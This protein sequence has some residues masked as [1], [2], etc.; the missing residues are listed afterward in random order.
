MRSV[1]GTTTG[2]RRRRAKLPKSPLAVL[3]YDPDRQAYVEDDGPAP[4]TAARMLDAIHRDDKHRAMYEEEIGFAVDPTDVIAIRYVSSVPDHVERVEVLPGLWGNP[5]G[6]AN[7][8]ANDLGDGEPFWVWDVA[9]SIAEARPALEERRSSTASTT[10]SDD[11]ESAAADTLVGPAGA[12]QPSAQ[13]D[14]TTEPTAVRE[15]E[16]RGSYDAQPDGPPNTS[17]PTEDQ[18]QRFQFLH[19]Y[20][21]ERLELGVGPAML[22]FSRKSKTFGYFAPE[23][24]RRG[25]KEGPALSEISLN[26]DGLDRDPRDSAATI[27]HELVHQWHHE[28]GKPG[29]RGYHNKEWAAKME[30]IGLMP[31]ST[32]APG[33]DKTG[34]RVSHYI[35]EG[36]PFA[37]AFA[38]LPPGAL[39]PFVSG[40]PV[41]EPLP[42]TTPKPKDPSKTPFVCAAG[43]GRKWW[44]KAS[45]R[46]SVACKQ[47]GADF[48]CE[49]ATGTDTGTPDTKGCEAGN[50]R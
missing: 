37:V 3:A 11:G 25:E 40:A 34:Q 24:W 39:L 44:G 31:S 15:S 46:D 32:G 29:R 48:V 23:R 8:F 33:G 22:A 26:P 1:A 12:P 9:V 35:I 47:C 14:I 28:N 16:D 17:S 38:A 43:C 20:F 50:G 42:P 18:Y 36:G 19:G 13:S 5:S 10:A 30:S 6:R 7:L 45:L 21:N 41:S 4:V 49:V 27:V 2:V